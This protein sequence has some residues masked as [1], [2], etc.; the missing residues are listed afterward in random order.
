MGAVMKAISLVWIV[1]LMFLACRE[2]GSQLSQ[3]SAQKT[4]LQEAAPTNMVYTGKRMNLCEQGYAAVVNTV[5]YYREYYASQFPPSN[6]VLGCQAVNKEL[7]AKANDDASFWQ[8]R[9]DEC[10]AAAQEHGPAREF[11][12]VK[13]ATSPP[14]YFVSGQLNG[15]GTTLY[16]STCEGAVAEHSA[17]DPD[18]KLAQASII[19][20]Y[21]CCLKERGA[22]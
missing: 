19:I 22:Q 16:P 8:K 21:S 11:R 3:D 20:P 1:A 7:K 9:Q 18:R 15:A 13:G 14:V 17:L 6:G 2:D 5:R 10:A 12:F 4:S